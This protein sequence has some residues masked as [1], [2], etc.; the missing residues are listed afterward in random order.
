MFLYLTG[1]KRKKKK[2]KINFCLDVSVCLNNNSHTC[3]IRLAS[4]SLASELPVHSLQLIVLSVYTSDVMCKS[5]LV[6]V[7]TVDCCWRRIFFQLLN[8]VDRYGL[9]NGLLGGGLVVLLNR[10]ASNVASYPGALTS[11][12]EKDF[13]TCL[14]IP[15][16][17]LGLWSEWMIPRNYLIKF[18]FVVLD[19]RCVFFLALRL[20]MYECEEATETMPRFSL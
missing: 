11:G 6:H 10:F 5:L 15:T 20:L 4:E 13:K 8:T 16:S 1:N 18:V 2:E 9:C 17:N 7:Y 19:S 14:L 3:L 12:D